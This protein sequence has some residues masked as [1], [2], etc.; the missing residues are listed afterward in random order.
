MNE[1]N[2]SSASEMLVRRIYSIS[3]LVSKDCF[4]G[5]PNARNI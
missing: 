1:K 2:V 3:C 4:C 5:T